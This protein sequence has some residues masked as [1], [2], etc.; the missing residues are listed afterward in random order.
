[1]LVGKLAC[2]QFFNNALVGSTGIEERNKAQTHVDSYN[3]QQYPNEEIQ[4]F[5][6]E[7]FVNT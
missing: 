4:P 2:L 3:K 5:I 1:M 7:Y 6:V